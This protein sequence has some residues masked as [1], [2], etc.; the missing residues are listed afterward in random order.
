MK[1]LYLD[2]NMGAAGDML[3][4][5]LLE[6]LP[7]Q[8]AFL[9]ELNGVGLPGVFV[10]TM[11]S[12]KCGIRGTHFKV[13]VHGEEEE[14]HDVHDHD[15]HHNHDHHHEHDHDHHHHHGHEHTH[16]HVH[17]HTSMADIEHLI[18][19]HLDLQEK[20]RDD[21]LNVYAL[22][23]EAES[24][25]HGVSVSEIHFHEV[26]MMDAIMDVTAVCLLINKIA[27]DR[28]VCSPV[29]TGFGKVRCA[30]GILPVPVPAAA[31]LLKEIPICAGNIEGELCTP[32]GAA[33]IKYF[34]DSFGNM[35]VMKVEKIGYGMG[36]KDFPAANC[37]RTFLG[38]SDEQPE[39]V[40]EHSCNVDDMTAE[41]IGFAQQKLFEAGAL[42]VYT[43]PI[44]MKKNRP[45]TLIRIMCSEQKKMEVI[46][47]IFRHTTTLGI[48]ENRLGRYVLNRKIDTLE[49]SLG[50]VRV[51]HAEGYGISRSKL[52]FEDLSRIATEQ[53]IS[54]KEAE[55]RILKDSDRKG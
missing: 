10:E 45:G 44:G 7:D 29:H 34:A 32:T 2:C 18:R 47:A 38:E 42:D 12:E 24:H 36:K 21:V 25:A 51:K 41:A 1:T 35:P 30:H 17:S 16:D 52:E 31:Y 28:I 4:A 48:R 3:S 5:S 8:E 33:L 6:L 23:A 55:E 20:V 39:E 9:E 13:T 15:H 19:D 43:I 22:I 26:G 54:L 14:S 46:A 37:L 49:T 53:G 11:P 40:F 27:P 50:Q